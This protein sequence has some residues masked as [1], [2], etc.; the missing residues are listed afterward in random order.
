MIRVDVVASL[1]PSPSLSSLCVV[2][3]LLSWFVSWWRCV[4]QGHCTQEQFKRAL[5][6]G[7]FSGLNEAEMQALA[8]KYTNVRGL[9]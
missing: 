6:S 9:L 7:K 8:D 2:V 5:I 1:S 4:F 3:P